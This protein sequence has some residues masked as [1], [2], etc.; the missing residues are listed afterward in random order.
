VL[1][2]VCSIWDISDGLEVGRRVGKR[3]REE[4]WVDGEKGDGWMKRTTK[5]AGCEERMYTLAVSQ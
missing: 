1:F 2:S 5:W 4:R 3:R